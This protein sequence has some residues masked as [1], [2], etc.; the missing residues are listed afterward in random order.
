[1]NLEKTLSRR[2]FI[3]TLGSLG[4]L[5]LIPSSANA[6]EISDL[7]NAI[8]IERW[9][10]L[11]D[12]CKGNSR[13]SWYSRDENSRRNIAQMYSNTGEF[14][15]RLTEK[16]KIELE[17]FDRAYARAGQKSET[18]STEVFIPQNGRITEEY[19]KNFPWIDLNT[20]SYQDKILIFAREVIDEDTKGKRIDW[21][22]V[23]K[24]GRE[25]HRFGELGPRKINHN[26]KIYYRE[27]DS[28][29]YHS[30]DGNIMAVD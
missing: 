18:P 27:G 29:I 5:A 16:Q 25:D 22:Y 17:E 4:A 3:S 20:P 12:T 24:I 28:N 15:T 26:G 11:C 10:S 14:L 23:K 30:K 1:M 6:Q 2:N 9:N 21:N 19:H 7:I 8:G 13:K